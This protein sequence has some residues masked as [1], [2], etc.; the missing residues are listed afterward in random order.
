TSGSQVSSLAT[1]TSPAH[2]VAASALG[3][4]GRLRTRVVPTWFSAAPASGSP[5]S[6][7]PSDSPPESGSLASVG[8]AVVGSRVDRHLA[9]A[10]PPATAITASTVRSTANLRLA[11]PPRGRVRSGGPYSPLRR[12]ANREVTVGQTPASRP[13]TSIV[14]GEPSAVVPITQPSTSRAK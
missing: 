10:S 9:N 6:S 2:P 11:P 1:W 14:P 4:S 13:L 8:A 12:R 3:S 5:P 7:K